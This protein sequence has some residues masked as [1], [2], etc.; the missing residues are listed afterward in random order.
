MKL[1]MLIYKNEII[2]FF[3]IISLFLWSLFATFLAF[4]NKSQVLLIGKTNSSYQ[5]IENEEKSPVETMNFIR[6]FIALTLNFDKKSYR[7]HISMAGDLMTDALWNKKNDEFKDM[8]SYIKEQNVIQS[9]EILSIKKQKK[10]FFEVKIRNYLF[11]KGTLTETDKFILLSLTEN[12][13][14]YKNPWRHSV[15]DIKVK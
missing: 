2:C 13:R 12:K 3:L 4:Q 10:N 11:K 15:S 5:I 9:S 1:L 8:A 6:H 7:K 14:N